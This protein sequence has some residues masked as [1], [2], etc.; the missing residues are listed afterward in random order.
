MVLIFTLNSAIIQCVICIDG[1][2]KRGQR[3][4]FVL[5]AV[6]WLLKEPLLWSVEKQW[7]KLSLRG[8]GGPAGCPWA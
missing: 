5:S 1:S 2:Y 6:K 3:R 7:F 8:C 4:S